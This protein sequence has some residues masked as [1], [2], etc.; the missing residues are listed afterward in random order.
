MSNVVVSSVANN[1]TKQELEQLFHDHYQLLYRTAYSMLNNHADAEDVPQTLFLRLLRSG[2]TPDLE[3]NA[4]GYL[5]RATVNLALDI[6][7]SRKRRSRD[8]TSGKFDIPAEPSSAADAE[9]MHQRLA[10][11]LAELD[12]ESAQML[13]LR[14]VH[15]YSDANIA[16]M[17]GA[18]R[19]TIAMRLL[20]ARSRLK[21]L[22][23]DSSGEKQ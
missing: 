18:S 14:Y 11:A 12:Q 1:T 7:R 4:K 21:K 22:I 23:R 8:E 6:V 17:M 20:R 15:N 3:R 5:Y 9:E 19:G 10:E 16:K 2:L 13:M